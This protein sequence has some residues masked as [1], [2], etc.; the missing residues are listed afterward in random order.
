MLYS[1]LIIIHNIILK[2]LPSSLL[3][4]ISC[5]GSD[6][7]RVH[8]QSMYVLNVSHSTKTQILVR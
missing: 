4:Y 2:Y 5:F 3:S 7:L 1:F 8:F 6:L